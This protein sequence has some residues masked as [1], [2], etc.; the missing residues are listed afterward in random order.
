MNTMA[1]SKSASITLWS[2][3]HEGNEVRCDLET[4]S[5]WDSLLPG[6]ARLVVDGAPLVSQPFRTVDEL[7][8]V[9]AD[10]HK[11]LPFAVGAWQ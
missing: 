9:T 2:V 11:H 7:I 10:W 6:T 5:R 4:W 8:A 3:T 1:A